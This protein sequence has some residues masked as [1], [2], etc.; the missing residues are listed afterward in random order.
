MKTKKKNKVKYKLLNLRR[1]CIGNIHVSQPEGT[2]SPLEMEVYTKDEWFIIQ[3]LRTK[4]L[5]VH[6]GI[7]DKCEQ[8]N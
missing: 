7:K 1:E 3:Q 2:T 4:G 6:V 8:T 5:I